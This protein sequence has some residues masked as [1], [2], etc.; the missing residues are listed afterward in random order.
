VAWHAHVVILG[1]AFSIS[2]PGEI[3]LHMIDVLRARTI[4]PRT[5]LDTPRGHLHRRTFQHLRQ[6]SGCSRPKM[7][8]L[9]STEQ[10]ARAT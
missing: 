7:S 5:W 1:V 4:E 6:G 3:R 2:V 9:L 10:M 8:N